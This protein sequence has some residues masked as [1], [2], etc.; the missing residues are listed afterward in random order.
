[1]R[2]PSVVGV[3]EARLFLLCFAAVDPLIACC[4]RMSPFFTSMHSNMRCLLFADSRNNLSPQIIGEE[5]PSP[6]RSVFQRMFS[7]ASHFTGTSLSVETPAPLGP[8]KRGQFAA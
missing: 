1:M 8:R 3:E 7:L 2:S 5:W 6:G 4:Q